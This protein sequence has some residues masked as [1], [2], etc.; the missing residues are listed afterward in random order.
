MTIHQAAEI[1]YA[2]ATDPSRWGSIVINKRKPHTYRAF[3]EHDEH[4]I[5]LHRFDACE[6]EDS[7]PHPHPWASSM[8]IL[9]GELRD[10]GWPYTRSEFGRTV[11]RHQSH[12][13]C[14]LNLS[15]ERSPHLASSHSPR[16]ATV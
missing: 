13:E 7:F 9:S 15:H 14:G 1:P 4:R 8:L 12:A 11:S 10:G 2:A 3:L 5:C 6:P 16:N